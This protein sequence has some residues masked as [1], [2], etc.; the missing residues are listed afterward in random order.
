MSRGYGTVQRQILADL[1][2]RADYWTCS[3]LAERLGTDPQAVR[4]ALPRLVTDRAVDQTGS[5]Q[6]DRLRY[7]GRPR[8]D[9]ECRDALRKANADAAW[10][11][12]VVGRID[13]MPAAHREASPTTNGVPRS[14]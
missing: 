12:R 7:Y 3:E 4:Q 8:T 6:W 1:A 14:R 10:K 11:G 5:R 2:A 9:E 13:A